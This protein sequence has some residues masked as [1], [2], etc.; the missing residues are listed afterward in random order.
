MPEPKFRVVVFGAKRFIHTVSDAVDAVSACQAA[1]CLRRRFAP[2]LEIEV[3][4]NTRSLTALCQELELK[5]IGKIIVPAKAEPWPKS[6]AS[7]DVP[8]D[9]VVFEPTGKEPEP[10]AESN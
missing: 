7:P 1:R 6:H 2:A 9:D 8:G 10:P 3:H 5:G 4:G